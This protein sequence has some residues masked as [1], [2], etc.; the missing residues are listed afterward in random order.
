M[1]TRTPAGRAHKICPLPRYHRDIS[2]LLLMEK[3]KTP[4]HDDVSAAQ[5]VVAWL[6]P[7][8]PTSGEHFGEHVDHDSGEH[9]VVPVDSESRGQVAADV[10]ASGE[11]VVNLARYRSTVPKVGTSVARQIHNRLWAL[12][13]CP[14]PRYHRDI[15][16]LP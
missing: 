8:N 6:L 13:I 10:H 16:I 12:K 14:L 1:R 5:E 15:S 2:T 3:G 4:A 7:D 11:P 9:L